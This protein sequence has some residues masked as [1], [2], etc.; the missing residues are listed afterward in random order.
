MRKLVLLFCFLQILFGTLWVV[1]AKAPE[2]RPDSYAYGTDEQA[3]AWWL[4]SEDLPEVG[5]E[6]Y[7]DPEIPENYV[8]V[9]GEDELYMVVGEDGKIE[10]YRR[11]IRQEDGTWLWK[12]ENPDIPEEYEAVEGLDNV[13][14]VTNPDGSVKYLRYIRNEDDTYCFVEV[15]E[16][17][18]EIKE[19]TADGM[20]IPENYHRVQGNVYAVVNE[21]GVVTGYMERILD[22]DGT[23]HW[24]ECEKPTSSNKGTNG[25]EKAD[26]ADTSGKGENKGNRTEGD[27]ITI[28]NPGISKEEISGGGYVET[29]TI[30]DKKTSGGWIITYQTVV[31]RT[32]DANG[33]LISTKKDGPREVSKVQSVTGSGSAPDTNE[34]RT[35]LSEEYE[36]VTAGLNYRDDIAAGV[37][38]QLNEERSANGLAALAMAAD[39]EV[40]K[41]ARIKAAD[42]A[43]YNHSDFDSPMYGDL[44]GLLNRFGISSAAPSETLWRTTATKTAKDIHT[45]FQVQEYSRA[46]RMSG[47]YTQVGIAVVEKNGY[48]Y[49]AE[50]FI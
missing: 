24:Q 38:S 9:L 23:Y 22:S 7:L 39:S 34:I 27:G 6:W 26:K 42:M 35:T 33:K 12:D 29:E 30:V 11:R 46:A 45:R 5:E 17:G 4:Q 49:I 19:E 48:L 18:K 40:F 15:D 37:L 8:P 2:E 1:K 41:I 32:Y 14:K 43:I 10:G 16:H 13:Y 20:V 50:I 3:G 28:L 44:S 36:R 21:H 47:N 31:T 25:R